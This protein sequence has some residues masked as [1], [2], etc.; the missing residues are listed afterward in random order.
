MNSNS[1]TRC[2]DY[3]NM[4]STYDANTPQGRAAIGRLLDSVPATNVT[5]LTG[6]NV[7]T[8][9]GERVPA[10]VRDGNGIRVD[11]TL[12]KTQV[13]KI[14]Y[15]QF[16]V[17]QAAVRGYCSILRGVYARLGITNESLEQHR[18]EKPVDS[19]TSGP[20]TSWADEVEAE[21]PLPQVPQNIPNA[22]SE[23]RTE[24]RCDVASESI[25]DPRPTVIDNVSPRRSSPH[26]TGK[27]S[28]ARRTQRFLE[29]KRLEKELEL[30]EEFPKEESAS[31]VEPSSSK[32][33]VPLND[34]LSVTYSATNWRLLHQ[35]AFMDLPNL[36]STLLIHCS[37]VLN[38]F[39][40]GIHMGTGTAWLPRVA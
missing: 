38:R 10:I 20:S 7:R 3:T 19:E 11:V 40:V 25:E 12:S 33:V 5:I 29:K 6:E 34:N 21:L 36:T 8:N 39:F 22:A 37:S 13:R 30:K 15:T 4:E 9:P 32:S 35:F 24:K 17:K 31:R 2:V 16:G 1:S 14:E 23:S 27:G 26:K 18:M 28:R